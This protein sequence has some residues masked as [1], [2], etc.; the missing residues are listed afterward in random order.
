MPTLN[1]A[2]SIGELVTALRR[3]PRC[4]E[5]IVVDGGSADGTVAAA[6]AA[7]ARVLTS[8]PGRGRQLALGGAEAHGEVLL[9]L[10]ADTQLPASALDAIVAA[11]RV[12]SLIGGNF[13]IRFDGD[14]GFARWLTG[15]YAWFRRHGLFYGDSA[16]FLRRE[17]YRRLGGIRPIALMEDYD[18]CRRMQRLGPV[19]C[20]DDPVVTTSSRRF[21]GRQPA[22]IVGQWL[23]L[24]ALYHLRVPPALLARLYNSARRRR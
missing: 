14:S 19:C 4:H 10:H 21:E 17:S 9:F 8:P 22:A 3:S 18:L 2:G 24:H 7:G 16:I 15:F 6:D 23:L 1:E 12:D 5:V 11:M 20:I 13:R